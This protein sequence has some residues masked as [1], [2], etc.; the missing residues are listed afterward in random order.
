MERGKGWGAPVVLDSGIISPPG[1]DVYFG[2]IAVNPLGEVVIGFSGSGPNDYPSAYAVAG[3]LNGDVLQF[4]DPM[5]LKAGVAPADLNNGRFGDYSATTY[6]P[7]D[8][9]HFWTI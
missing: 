6:D 3:S 4:G 8:P 9:S 5:L 7:A 1:L 2:S